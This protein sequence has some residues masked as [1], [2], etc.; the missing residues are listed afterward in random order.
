MRSLVLVSLLLSLGLPITAAITNAVPLPS[1]PL[2][3]D[4]ALEFALSHNVTLR[5]GRQDLEE[6][7]GLAI[8]QRAARLPRLATT[9]GY[10]QL[11]ESRI[12]KVQFSAAQPATPFLNNQSW[13]ANLVVTQPI[14]A[15]GKYNSMARSSR[16]TREAALALYQALVANTLLEVRTAYSDVLLAV[17]QIVVQEASKKLLERELETARRS[18]EAGTVPKFNVLRAEVELANAL[19]P[20]IRARNQER[21]FRNTLA[22]LLGCDIPADSGVDIPLRTADSLKAEPF[23]VSVGAA[24]NAAWVHR[25]EIKAAQSASQLRH[26]EVLQ[27][28]ADLLPSVSGIAGYGVQNRNFVRDLDRTLDGWTVGVQANWLLFDFGQTQAKVNM[29]RAREER[30]RLEVEDVRRRIE[31]E[32]RTAFSLFL[33]S[34]EV[35]L[36]QTR[37]IEQAEEAV[38]LVTA[39]ADA[40]SSTQLEVLSAQTALKLSRT[41]YSQ[42]LRDYTVARAKLERAMGEGVRLV[43]E[44]GRR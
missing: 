44:T 3:L 7:Q 40:G 25:P 2:T 31:L 5:K 8:Q 20:L 1:Q 9:G 39:R 41:Q 12:E 22:L 4:Q 30:A 11:D 23:E 32:V 19:P 14:Y 27:T 16:L 35:L 6:A 17:E 10:Q 42:A 43:I 38:R 36:S 33:E 24:L 15:G 37:V 29:A 34:K 18:L 26:E 13:N 21:I 28:R